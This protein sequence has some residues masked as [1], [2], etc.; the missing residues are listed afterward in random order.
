[1]GSE[2]ACYREFLPGLYLFELLIPHPIIKH[3]CAYLSERDISSRTRRLRLH[4]SP[5]IAETNH[6]LQRGALACME[7]TF[8]IFGYSC[9]VVRLL[10]VLLVEL[11][12]DMDGAVARLFLFLYRK[13]PCVEAPTFHAMRN[14]MHS[15]GWIYRY[16]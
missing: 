16:S 4:M 12:S 6:P 2:W 1:V 13:P 5:R 3:Y 11:T 9:S 15:N 8:N 14:W 10:V 7:F